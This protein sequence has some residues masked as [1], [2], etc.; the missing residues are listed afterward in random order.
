MSDAGNPEL[1]SKTMALSILLAVVAAGW[2]TISTLRAMSRI[3]D[4]R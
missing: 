4:A 3:D 2:M 1:R